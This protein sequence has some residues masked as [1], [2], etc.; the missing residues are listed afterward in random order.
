MQI[1]NIDLDVMKNVILFNLLLIATMSLFCCN[2]YKDQQLNQKESIQVIEESLQKILDKNILPKEYYQQP[3]QI[4]TPKGFDPIEIKVNGMKCILL[5][6]E[7]NVNRL[8]KG[9]D[10]FTPRPLV[11]IAELK[12]CKELIY[13]DLIFRATG[14]NFSLQLKRTTKGKLEITKISERT[15]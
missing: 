9:M 7:T 6:E 13:I 14:H 15:I 11:E 5:P 10:I 12:M 4:V 8:I 2:R 1:M 3:L